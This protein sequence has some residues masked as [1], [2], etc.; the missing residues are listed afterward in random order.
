MVLYNQG[1]YY[2]GGGWV[3]GRLRK[4]E[5]PKSSQAWEVSFAATDT[6]R[7]EKWKLTLGA[8]T[9]GVDKAWV[10]LQR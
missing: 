8:D 3:V 4:R 7:A 2:H 6:S 5:V 9:R 1:T 10:L